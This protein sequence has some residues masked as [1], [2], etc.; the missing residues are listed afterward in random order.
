MPKATFPVEEKL[1][2]RAYMKKLGDLVP[3][4]SGK[5]SLVTLAEELSTEKVSVLLFRGLSLTG[6][7]YFFGAYLLAAERPLYLVMNILDLVDIAM[8]NHSIF[9]SMDNVRAECLLLWGG[10]HETQNKN[11]ADYVLHSLDKRFLMGKRTCLA[12]R[13]G[14]HEE[15]DKKLREYPQAICKEFD[16]STLAK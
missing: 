8:H 12:L 2:V 7:N 6:V 5:E 15:L 11:L 4:Q 1:A 13:L 14:R 10:F 9:K 16:P 3:P